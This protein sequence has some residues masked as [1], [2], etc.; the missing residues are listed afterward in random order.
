MGVATLPY[1]H[2]EDSK[3][4]ERN[5]DSKDSGDGIDGI[6]SHGDRF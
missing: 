5:Q 2:S 4:E 6:E 3:L 1:V